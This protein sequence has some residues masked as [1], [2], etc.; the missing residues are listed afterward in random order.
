MT[1]TVYELFRQ[2]PTKARTNEMVRLRDGET[3]S[4]S[5]LGEACLK[6]D[7]TAI[8][9]ILDTLGYKDDEGAATELSFQMWIDQVLETLNS[10]KKGDAAFKNK[11]FRAAIECYTKFIDVGTMV[12]P[13]VYAH[14]SLSYLM[15]DM[16]Q[17]ALNDAVQAHVISLV[18]H[19]ASYLQAASL[20]TLGRENEAVATQ[21][22]QML[23]GA[24]AA[25]T[26]QKICWRSWTS[27]KVE[28]EQQSWRCC[29]SLVFDENGKQ[30][31]R[32][33]RVHGR[34]GRQPWELELELGDEDEAAAVVDVVGLKAAMDKRKLKQD[35]ERLMRIEKVSLKIVLWNYRDRALQSSYCD[36]TKI[37][38]IN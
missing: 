17:E 26:Q 5:P 30:Q 36:D 13:T 28:L 10:K 27:T 1:L 21:L 15:S 18:W 29:C 2:T 33:A 4:L 8:H 12:S 9:E 3:M 22:K 7:L 23:D 31:K 35:N 37:S 25:A 38:S 32:G 34:L 6:T 11:D 19:I 16:P 14:R 24:K 20:F